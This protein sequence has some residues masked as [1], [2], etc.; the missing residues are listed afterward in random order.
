MMDHGS[1]I[2]G[3]LTQP[4]PVAS[5]VLRDLPKYDEEDLGY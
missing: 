3:L 2:I 4:H 5:G 1:W